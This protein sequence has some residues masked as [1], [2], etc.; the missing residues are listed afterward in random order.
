MR[1]RFIFYKALMRISPPDVN[2]KYINRRGGWAKALGEI[3][4]DFPYAVWFERE[5]E[6]K[7]FK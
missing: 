3:K 7:E 1:T 5:M 4:A 6:Q 2:D